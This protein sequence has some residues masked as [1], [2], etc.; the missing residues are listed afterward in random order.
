[1][2]KHLEYNPIVNTRVFNFGKN[3]VQDDSN[4]SNQQHETKDI[5]NVQFKEI[6]RM[7]LLMSI[8][9]DFLEYDRTDY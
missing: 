5:K 4:S 9:Q 7:F 3:K 1:M 8:N 2:L 6:Y